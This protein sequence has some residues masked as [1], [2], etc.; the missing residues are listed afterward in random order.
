MSNRV[1]KDDAFVFAVVVLYICISFLLFFKSYFTTKIA[2]NKI[3]SKILAYLNL[4]LS[5]NGKFYLYTTC[6]VIG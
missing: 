2:K 6:L 1:K 4:N 3:F 5:L